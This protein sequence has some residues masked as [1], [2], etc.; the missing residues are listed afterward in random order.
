MENTLTSANEHEAFQNVKGVSVLSFF[1][2]FF[3]SSAGIIQLSVFSLLL[4]LFTSCSRPDRQQVDQLNDAS[5]AFHYRNLDSTL[6]YANLAIECSQGYAAGRAE[7]MNN[8]AFVHIMRMEYDKAD[9]ILAQVENITNNQ[10]ELYV[11]GVQQMRLCQRRSNNKEFYEHREQVMHRQR[12]IEE[13]RAMLTERENHRLLYAQSEY[14]IVLSTYYYYVGL[15]QQSIDALES[16]DVNEVENDTVQFLAYLYNVGAGGIITQ[17]TQE[18]INQAEF[19]Y[20]LRCYILANQADCPFWVANSMQAMSEHLFV[21]QQRDKLIADN[22]P[23]MKFINPDNMPDSLLAGYLAQNSLE[24][25]KEYGD[26]YQTAGSYRTL[27]SCYMAVDDYNSALICLDQALENNL[28]IEQAPDLVASIREQLSVTYSAINDKPNSDYNRNLYLDKQEL[29]RQ[30]RQLEARAEQLERSSRQLNIM[31]WAVVLMI[32]FVSALLYFFA[33]LRR[34]TGQRQSLELLLQPLNEWK[35]QN[36]QELEAINEHCEEVNEARALSLVHIATNKKRNIENRAKIF[37]VNSITPFI[38]RMMHE[39]HKLETDDESPEKRG[40]RYEYI[41][42][43]TDK[44]NDYNNV[45]TQWIQLR[46]GELSLHI[47]SFPLQALFDTVQKS[48][49]S[50][51]LKGITLEVKPTD[52][53]VKA[54][55]ILTL[56]MINTMADNARKFTPDGGRVEVY[57]S[58][59]ADYVEISVADTGKGMSQEELA[60]VFKHQVIVDNGYANAATAEADS[61]TEEINPHLTNVKGHFTTVKPL[62]A[63][64]NP[65][66]GRTAS[67]NGPSASATVQ[68]S[69]GYGLMNCKGIIE[70][71]R[72]VSQIFSVCH[73]DVESELGKGSR[74]FFRLPKGGTKMASGLLNKTAGA[75]KALLCLVLTALPMS[76][77]FADNLSYE[78]LASQYADSAY[79]SNIDGTYQRTL[80][81][82]DSVRKYV[83][84]AYLQT[85]KGSTDTL[86][87]IGDVSAEQPEIR[88]LHDSVKVNFHVILDIRNESAVAALALHDWQ[89]YR[90]NNRVYT[91]LFK[92]MSADNSLGEYCRVMQKSES[93]KR[94]AI[95]ILLLLLFSLFPAFYMLYYRHRIFYRF[96]LDRVQRINGVLLTDSEPEEKLRRIEPMVSEKYPMELQRVVEQI[97]QTLNESVAT[98][99]MR[100]TSLEL[101]EDEYRRAEFENEKLHISNSVLDNCLSTL[102]HETMYYPSRIRQLVDG[103]D[104]NLTAISE[105]ATYYKELYTQLS[106]QAMR[107]VE[108]VKFDCKPV[109]WADMFSCRDE[110][111]ADNVSILGDSDLLRYLFDLL[112]TESGERMLHTRIETKGDHYAVITVAMPNLHLTDEECQQ[113]FTPSMQHM[114]YMLCRQIVRDHSLLTARR[115]C[116][117]MAEPNPSGGT[118][119]IVTLTRASLPA[120]QQQPIH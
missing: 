9:S 75:A 82:A 65:Y 120:T 33:R 111:E 37:L 6:H 29:T 73:I 112:R 99:N 78:N 50:F 72:K 107:Q 70:K 79:Y 76:G 8:Q 90:Y 62:S 59:T 48:R 36:D 61:P 27:A 21:A 49:M 55:R 101:A 10:I 23:A 117:I 109:P 63:N 93:N 4:L 94:V 26:V 77:V 2:S 100:H 31:I 44:I 40:E 71:Y 98:K 97:K 104:Q 35:A 85:V 5:Y 17:G 110:V 115:G 57:A 25:F 64:V 69:H 118:N 18:E 56:F 16:I 20:L 60:T 108:S 19:D 114:P 106:A 47:E 83:N 7:A 103:T 13:E 68:S 42:E 24:I 38:D 89:L 32:L 102:K 113:L 88:W 86:L 92:E 96:C 12:R 53:V 39:V 66:F 91:Q 46:Q 80:Q 84:A 30:D 34:Q 51:Q 1:C 74:F 87:R 3:V 67:Q 28:A 58:E 54:D 45:L 11:A 43:L 41:T 22:L 95:A 105:L 116:G 15:E 119:I 52:A 81:F 14:A